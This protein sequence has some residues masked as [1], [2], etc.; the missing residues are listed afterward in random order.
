MKIINIENHSKKV[1]LF[2][3]P[4]FSIQSPTTQ[5]KSPDLHTDTEQC[6]RNND[7]LLANSSSQAPQ[8]GN[9]L[10]ENSNWVTEITIY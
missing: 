2:L 4:M 9:Y 3:F 5:I 6:L 1:N 7:S 8:I 10:R